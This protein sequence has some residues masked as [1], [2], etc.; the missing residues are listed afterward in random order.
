MRL[1]LK[2]P[3]LAAGLLA[4]LL[5][6]G[7]VPSAGPAA[8]APV[9]PVVENPLELSKLMEKMEIAYTELVK[10]IMVAP[11]TEDEVPFDQAAGWA[12]EIVKV[13]VLFPK[14]KDFENEKSFQ[15]FARRAKAGAERIVRL[16][17]KQDSKPM[18]AALLGI[19]AACRAC[20]AKHRL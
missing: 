10:I 2:M 6:G 14:V 4:L 16:A 13:G 20:H 18:V 9:V 1:P 3:S 7:P 11:V 15:D 12:K 17:E 8:A 5:T 19:R